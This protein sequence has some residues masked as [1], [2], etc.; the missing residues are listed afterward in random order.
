MS[1]QPREC[2]VDISIK[3]EISFL[4][5]CLVVSFSTKKC[6]FLEHQLLIENR[7]CISNVINKFKNVHLL[8]LAYCPQQSCLCLLNLG[9]SPIQKETIRNEINLGNA[10]ELKILLWLI[11][12][13]GRTSDNRRRYFQETPQFQQLCLY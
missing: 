7:K 13:D 9:H 8:P 5:F 6:F 4:V 11:L 1:S 3:I 12:C 10:P 2:K